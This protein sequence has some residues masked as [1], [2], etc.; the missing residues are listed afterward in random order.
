MQAEKTAR[1]RL[2]ICGLP[3]RGSYT[4]AEVCKILE[5]TAHIFWRM[6]K[7]YSRSKDGKLVRP[8]CLESFRFSTNRRVTYIELV[9]FFHR[10]NSWPQNAEQQPQGEQSA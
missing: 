8:D 9:S 2:N 4:P 3:L 1:E 5:I 10:N 6:T 7:T